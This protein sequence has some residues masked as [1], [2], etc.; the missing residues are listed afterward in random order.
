MLF[1]GDITGL[2]FKIYCLDELLNDSKKRL[3]R[4]LIEQSMITATT[5]QGFSI[6]ISPI[7]VELYWPR[8]SIHLAI[9]LIWE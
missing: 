2:K 3:D 5:K 7:M 6:S 8:S 9:S 1:L 4:N